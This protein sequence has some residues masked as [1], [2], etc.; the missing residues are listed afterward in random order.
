MFLDGGEE[1]RRDMAWFDWT[2]S[3]PR[4]EIG[5]FF[6]EGNIGIAIARVAVLAAYLLLLQQAALIGNVRANPMLGSN[7]YRYS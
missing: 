7:D 2:S 5:C 3:A 4:Y 1:E 6:C